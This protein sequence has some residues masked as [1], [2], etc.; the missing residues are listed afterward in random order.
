MS[1]FK[2]SPLATVACDGC[3]YRIS[4]PEANLQSYIGV[5]CPDCGAVMIDEPMYMQYTNQVGMSIEQMA[6]LLRG[7]TDG[8]ITASASFIHKGLDHAE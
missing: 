2:Y 6:E 7:I 5:R 3:E 4:V 1:G 8:E